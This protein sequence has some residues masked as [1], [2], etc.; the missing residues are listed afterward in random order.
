MLKLRKFL[1]VCYGYLAAIFLIASFGTIPGLLRM[2]REPHHPQAHIGPL[3]AAWG[4]VLLALSRL[5]LAI[6]PVMAVLFAMAWWTI[7]TGKPSARRWALTSSIVFLSLNVPIYFLTYY[8]LAHHMK[9]VPPSFYIFNSAIVAVG[10]TGL[11]AFWRRDAASQPVA[12]PRARIAGDGT[13]STL[14]TLAGLLAGAGVLAGMFL[15]ERWGRA[16]GLYRLHGY[17]YWIDILFIAFITTSIHELGHALV[18]LSLGM[19]LRSFVLGPFHWF[20][21][22]GRWNF[23][24]HPAG[25]ISAEGV[26]GVV[27]TDP[28]QSRW[29]LISMIAAGPLANLLTGLVALA[30]ALAA[31][32][33]PY[34]PAW[35]S[36]FFIAT[37]S[38]VTFASN[39][40]PIRGDRLYSDGA[41]IY[42]VLKG[43]PWADLYRSLAIAGATSVTALRPRDYDMEAI[44]RASVLF[45]HG[46]QAV[47]LR[48]LASDHYID[49]ADFS[50]ARD[51]LA[52]AELVYHDSASEIPANL[53][54]IFVYDNALLRR[55][56]A[57]TRLWWDR[58]ESK[59]PTHFSV[60]Y[61][62]ARSALLWM[63]GSRSE[64]RK[65]WAKANDMAQ[66]RPLAG[67]YEFDRDRV[68]LLGKAMDEAELCAAL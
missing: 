65:A 53:H 3:L 43:G 57:G 4:S 7:K 31:P 38:L 19:K 2:L 63:E 24:F 66:S 58:L 55:D 22:D 6:P 60:D 67:V 45:K 15:Y 47:L 34:E 36:L 30:A 28:D 11:A 21:R 10:I 20:T 59:K 54:S 32:G 51:A 12:T 23:Q 40:L 18:G 8:L 5:V 13:S 52:D 26:T 27:P 17:A 14:D 41:R 25:I 9:G 50:Q 61:W 64:A 44:Q 39:L 48:L 68:A 35:D 33:R 29:S 46:L 1:G 49:V 62:L 56:A 37:V 16:H 42:Q